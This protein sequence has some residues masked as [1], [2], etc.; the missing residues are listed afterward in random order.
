MNEPTAAVACSDVSV[1][2]N[3]YTILDHVSV[4]IP[5]NHLAIIFGPNGGGKTTFL[6]LLIGKVH[7]S[8]GQVTVLGHSPEEARRSVGYVS[9]RVTAPTYFPMTVHKA[10][11]MG[12]F[13]RIGILRRPSREDHD[14]VRESLADVGLEGF[15]NHR[16]DELSGG[17]LQRVFIA[18]ALA[19]RPRLLLLDEATSGVDVG[20]RES[21]FALLNRL[22]S[23]M[24][25]IF[26][27]HDMSVVSTAV[28]TVLCLNVRLVSHGRPE[29]ALNDHA[30][31]C[32]YGSNI[33]VFSHCHT[34]HVH[35]GPHS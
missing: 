17:Q 30:L 22:K 6:N 24:T 2:L 23:R 10:V 34:P 26:V 12:R 19:S 16:L 32:M 4:S 31:Q 11:L 9:Q 33:A 1:T 3:G 5:E 28:D 13:G 35:V 7:P 25:V 21:L 20:A 27:T 18:R 8:S 14:I 15:G 29:V